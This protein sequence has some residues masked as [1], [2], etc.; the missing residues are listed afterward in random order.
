MRPCQK[1]AIF[2]HFRQT[3]IIEKRATMSNFQST[4]FIAAEGPI[5]IFFM[6][7]HSYFINIAANQLKENTE[8]RE[9]IAPT[10]Q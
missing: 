3:T 7:V 6:A 2:L 4:L 1:I 8:I 5:L 9:V 10:P